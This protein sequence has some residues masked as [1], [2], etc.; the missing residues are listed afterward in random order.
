MRGGGGIG[1]R[2]LERYE[3]LDGKVVSVFVGI[4]DLLEAFE[5]GADGREGIA[6]R[7]SLY[8]P[9]TSWPGA[10]AVPGRIVRW[11][12]G[13]SPSRRD[14]HAP[15]HGPVVPLPLTQDA[16]HSLPSQL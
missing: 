11:A 1:P 16:A 8:F 5:G 6:G 3:S 13:L 10:E 14:R 7:A 9:G 15:R 12:P 4:D 2:P